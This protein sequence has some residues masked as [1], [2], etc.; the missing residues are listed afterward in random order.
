MSLQ[1]AVQEVSIRRKVANFINVLLAPAGIELT[2]KVEPE[3]LYLKV[4]EA[5]LEAERT[6]VDLFDYL[7]GL[8]ALKSSARQAIDRLENLGAL[9]S[10]DCLVEIGAGSGTYLRELLERKSVSDILVYE[11]AEDWRQWLVSNYAVQIMQ[12]TGFSLADCPDKK[13]HVVAAHGVFVYVQVLSCYE[14]FL[15]MMRVCA[16]GAHIIFDYFPCED[17]SQKDAQF[18]FGYKY[19]YPLVLLSRERII[20]LF[21]NNHFQLVDRFGN[22]TRDTPPSEYLIFRSRQA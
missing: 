14:Y 7:E 22:I 6:G 20:E 12:A 16:P 8:L 18:W 11:L 17:F 5:L 9:S 4:A 1:G 10:C 13:A 21:D 2:R 15:E 19:R 3:R